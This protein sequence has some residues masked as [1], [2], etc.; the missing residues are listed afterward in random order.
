ML[1]FLTVL[2]PLHIREILSK[3][4]ETLSVIYL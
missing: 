3:N 1:R 4:I 2:P